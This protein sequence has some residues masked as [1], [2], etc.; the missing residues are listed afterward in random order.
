MTNQGFVSLKQEPYKAIGHPVYLNNK[1]LITD[2]LGLPSHVSHF[3]VISNMDSTYQLGSCLLSI[4]SCS[5]L[6]VNRLN[7]MQKV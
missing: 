5:V 7:R 4:A 6:P 2:A 1:R 3:T